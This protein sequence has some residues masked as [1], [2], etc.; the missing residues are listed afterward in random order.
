MRRLSNN[1]TIRLFAKNVV[2]T[3]EDNEKLFVA[4]DKELVIFVCNI[5][6]L[7]IRFLHH[8]PHKSCFSL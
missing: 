1:S 8:L 3:E 5:F 4:D 2:K 6:T 7:K